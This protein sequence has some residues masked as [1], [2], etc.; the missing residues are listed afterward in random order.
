MNGKILYVYTT[1][2]AE[3]ALG[4]PLRKGEAPRLAKSIEFSSVAEAI[5]TVLDQ[6]R[7]YGSED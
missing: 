2:D 6:F 5:D 3:A 4:R 1:A 7:D